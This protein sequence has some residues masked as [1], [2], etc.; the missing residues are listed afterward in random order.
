MTARILIVDDVP[1]NRRLLEAKLVAEYYQVSS[2]HDG[3]EALAV[4]RDWQPDLILL[5]VMMPGMDGYATLRAMRRLRSRAGVPLVA[6]TAKAEEGERQRCI[7]A[8]ASGYIPKPVNT[9]DLLAVL[10]EWIPSRS[11]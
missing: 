4:A 7:D 11:A 10:G 2:A 1:A 9:G 8:G 5:D 6:F 3:V